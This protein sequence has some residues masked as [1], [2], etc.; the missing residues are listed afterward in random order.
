MR[1]VS[2]GLSPAAFVTVATI[3]GLENVLDYIEGFVARFDRER[4]RDPAMYY[5]RVFGNPSDRGLWGWRFGGHHVSLKQ[6]RGGR[7]LFSSP[8]RCASW[9][10]IPRPRRYS[11][12]LRSARL[13][14]VEDLGRTWCDRCGPISPMARSCRRRPRSDFAAQLPTERCHRRRSGGPPTGRHSTARIGFRVAEQQAWSLERNA[15][16][17]S[18]SLIRGTPHGRPSHTRS[19][20]RVYRRRCRPRTTWRTSCRTEA[21]RRPRPGRGTGVAALPRRRRGNPLLYALRLAGPTAP[22]GAGLITRSQAPRAAHRMGQ[23]PAAERRT[24]S[25]P[26]EGVIPPRT[27]GLDVLSPKTAP[28]I[29]L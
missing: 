16:T 26:R 14:R 27:L 22:G 2:T 11:Q 13:V 9:V 19:N 1:L 5:L 7:R 3:M 10:R 20:P 12:E 4:G 29:T 21:L 24:T 17:S 25:T 6:P 18:A 28:G 15:T 23:H 8:P